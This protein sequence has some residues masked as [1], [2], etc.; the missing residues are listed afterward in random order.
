M[1]GGDGED[2][3]QGE[4]WGAGAEDEEEPRKTQQNGERSGEEGK[5]V[6]DRLPWRG[7]TGPW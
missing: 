6:V 4:G 5:S 2:R 3:P 1:D 7:G